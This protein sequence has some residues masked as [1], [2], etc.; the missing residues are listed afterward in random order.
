MKD[1]S[2][3]IEESL[4]DDEDILMNDID[5]M[6][7]SKSWIKKFSD[8]EKFDDYLEE[9]EKS[10][11]KYG[12]KKI[13]ASKIK[14]G[15]YMIR[16]FKDEL[17]DYIN[18]GFY[19]YYPA[20]ANNYRRVNVIKMTVKDWLRHKPYLKDQIRFNVSKHSVVDSSAL[21]HKRLGKMYS[22]PEKYYK[23]IDFIREKSK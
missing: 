17:G 23:L 3:Y 9:F 14:G 19:I 2:K 8:F 10:L 7:E 11:I 4:L 13:T 22:L 6:V 5:N 20:D 16:F 21:K 15:E 12:A 1:L 18:V